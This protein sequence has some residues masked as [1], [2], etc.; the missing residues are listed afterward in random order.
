[1]TMADE[2]EILNLGLS[3]YKET[4]E[5]MERLHHLIANKKETKEVIILV[6]H[7]RTITLG[8]RNLKDDVLYSEESLRKMDI[9]YVKTDRGGSAT[10]HEPGQ[11]VIYPLVRL[12]ERKISV[13]DY[14]SLLED[15]VI[16]VCQEFHIKAN[17]DSINP[18]VWVGKNKIAAIG[19]RIQNRVSKHGLAFNVNNDLSGF[20][21]IVPCGLKTRGVTSL[22]NETKSNSLNH[23]SI[24]ENLCH[25]LCHMILKK[26]K[27]LDKP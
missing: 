2:I 6:E 10:I 18:G 13:R 15:A 17:R 19:I 3:P 12:L 16:N 21:T 11:I 7:P 5:R 1:M 20:S 14:V 25:S 9:A 8:K 26:T 27:V 23:M 22:K 24:G 4:L